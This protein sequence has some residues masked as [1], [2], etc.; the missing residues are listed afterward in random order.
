MQC[1]TVYL[2]TAICSQYEFSLFTLP[3]TVLLP[4]TAAIAAVVRELLHS[5]HLAATRL[6]QLL[7]KSHCHCR[8]YT[9]AASVSLVLFVSVSA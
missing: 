4:H 9:A 7:S 6:T 5:C 2:Y 8:E 1:F 3:L